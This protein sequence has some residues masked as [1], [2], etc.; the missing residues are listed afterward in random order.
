M[1]KTFSVIYG[2]LA[3]VLFLGAF[4]YLVAFSMNLI[5]NS[6]SASSS[7]PPAVAVLINIALV[8]LFGLQHSIMARSE[9]KEWWTRVVPPHLERSTFVLI[10]SA[11]VA[12]IVAAWQPIGVE[13]WNVT[14]AG[15]VV[16]TAISVLGFLTV[17]VTSFLT[18]HFHLFG[19]RQVVEYAQGRPASEPVFKERLFYKKVRHPMMLGFLV[20]FWATPHMTGSHLLFAG[21]M[22]SYILA[23]IYFEESSLMQEHGDAYHAYQ[24]RVPKLLPVPGGSSAATVA[25]KSR[26]H[27]SAQ[28]E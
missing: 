6:V 1:K 26:A 27:A 9:F 19:L 28:A 5:S 12:L 2:V 21:L 24:A 10:G 17:P 7:L 14:G 23:G 11:L 22:T 18:D 13:I 15:M 25:P 3:Y 16:L 20:A 4:L 8:L